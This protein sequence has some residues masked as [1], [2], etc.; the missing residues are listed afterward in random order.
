MQTSQREE[1]TIDDA[2]QKSIG[3]FGAGQ[4]FIWFLV[5]CY[6]KAQ[7]I[8]LCGCP[9]AQQTVHVLWTMPNNLGDPASGRA[10]H[11]YCATVSGGPGHDPSGHAELFNG[12]HW[13]GSRQTG[14]VGL[15]QRRG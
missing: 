10:S 4:R 8:A 9:T 7:H 1:V 11:S 2:L 12:L 15:Q 3:E 13:N 14:L 5:I 6:P